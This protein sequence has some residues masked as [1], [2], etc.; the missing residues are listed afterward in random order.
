[1]VVHNGTKYVEIVSDIG[2]F[3]TL[4]QSN[5]PLRTWLELPARTSDGSYY[6]GEFG[7]GNDRNY[8]YQY[9]LDHYTAIWSAYPLT[10]SHLSGNGTSESWSFNPD[11]DDNLQ[12]NVKSNS[13]DKNYGGNYSRG[14]LIP[15]ADRKKNSTVRSQVYYL[16]NQ[17]PQIQ[18]GFNG[19]VWQNLETAVRNLTNGTDT[20]YVVT[21]ASFQKVGGNETIKTLTSTSSS[22]KPEKIYIPNY[23]WKV[24]LKVKRSSSTITSA[25]GIG[26]WMDHKTYSDSDDWKNCIY[27]VDQIEQ[28]TGL[29]FF[30]N[31]PGD[32][33]S[34]VEHDAEYLNYIPTG[35]DKW[36][37]FSNL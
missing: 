2:E 25:Y 32:N 4:S 29:D 3:T 7:S 14:H 15:A 30:T 21:G 35:S 31:L 9:D 23:F 18:N 27:S 10:K 20:V 5:A 36:S 12:I 1:M 11:I 13:Y 37:Y 34:G 16:T 26:I 22:I 33:S 8:S 6:Y 19:D 28:W 17:T 24:I